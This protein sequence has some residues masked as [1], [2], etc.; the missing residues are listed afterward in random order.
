MPTNRRRRVRGLID[1]NVPEWAVRLVN[2]GVAPQAG[3][4]GCGEWFGW[5]YCN[6]AVPGLPPS[7]S[8]EG[9]QLWADALDASQP[10][11]RL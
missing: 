5:L 10:R 2:E 11:R 7:D 4:D 1:R 8:P 9:E 6:D 3:E